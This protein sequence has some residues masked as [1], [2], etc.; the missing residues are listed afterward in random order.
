MGTVRDPVKQS[1]FIGHLSISR[2]ALHKQREMV[3]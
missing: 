1:T 3:V 2:A